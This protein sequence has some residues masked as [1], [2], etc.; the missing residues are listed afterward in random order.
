M[1]K[2]KLTIATLPIAV[3]IG[4]FYYYAEQSL[5]LRV[6]GL[7]VAVGVSVFIAMQSEHGRTAAAFMRD[8]RTEVRKVVWPTRKETAQVTLIVVALVI[9]VALFLWVSFRKSRRYRCLI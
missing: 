5:L 1:E 8:A 7:L 3:A 4:A 9:T 2:L 6:I